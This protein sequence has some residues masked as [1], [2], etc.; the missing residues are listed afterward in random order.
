MIGAGVACSDTGAAP[1]DSALRI[2]LADGDGQVARVGEALAEPLRVQVTQ[3]ATGVPESGIVVRWQLSAGTGAALNPLSSITD[4]EGFAQTRLTLG[5]TAGPYRVSASASGAPGLTTFGA[6][7]TEALAL[8]G[9]SVTS[10]TAGDVIEVKGTGF[11]ASPGPVIDF[12]GIPGTVLGST[13]T[14][15]SV[16]VPACLPTR[17]VSVRVVQGQDRTSPLPL[18]V[19]SQGASVQLA[20]GEDLLLEDTELL[21]CRRLALTAGAEYLVV[22]RSDDTRGGGAHEYALRALGPVGDLGTAGVASTLNASAPPTLTAQS[23]TSDPSVTWHLRLRALE[24]E[25]LTTAPLQLAA[26][27]S[28]TAP[29]AVGDSRTFPV[30][31][32]SGPPDTVDAVVRFVGSRVAI[33]EDVSA[34]KPG[35]SSDDFA[36]LAQEFDGAIY[37]RVTSVFGSEPDLDGNERVA[38]LLTPAVNR[39]TE[40]GAEGSV[41]G[42]FFTGDLL[43]QGGAPA[44]GEVLYALVP[45]PEGIHSGPIQ[46]ESIIGRIPAVLAHELQHLVHFN[47][48]VLI[49]GAASPEAL[50]LSEA[51]AHMAEDLVY[52]HYAGLG[53]AT[54][55]DAYRAWNMER[56][57]SYLAGTGDHS[58]TVSS[59]SGSLAE[60]G[61]GWLF[62]RYLADHFGGSRVL[63]DITQG[64][65]MGVEN[66]VQATGEPWSR[67]FS[68]WTV[69]LALDDL[70]VGPARFSLPSVALREAPEFGEAAVVERGLDARTFERRGSVRS[71]SARYLSVEP[72]V[73]NEVAVTLTGPGGSAPEVG[74]ALR[75]RI[76]RT[77]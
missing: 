48:R 52:E 19:S 33:Y 62:T 5:S 34:P 21:R 27:S 11:D 13:A 59:G 66:V 15:L 31:T 14:S 18:D 58:L 20:V 17:Q 4:S 39:L 25:L 16:T 60:R 75:V 72:A 2:R 69:A 47:A 26:P 71:A 53:V 40:R 28:A 70:D 43:S 8:T 32:R 45:D 68:D 36:T 54:R 57:R 61:A 42:F 10:A 73:G 76:V 64:A 51:L 55:A 67:T 44:N 49:A 41:A 56:A 74:A 65:Q 50:W 29:P 9:L 12:S 35:F 6:T 77:R 7:A 37:D 22:I 30:I 3:V 46:R 38:V 63:T 23:Q 24:A 1:E